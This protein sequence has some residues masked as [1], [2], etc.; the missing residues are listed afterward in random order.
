MGWLIVIVVVGFIVGFIIVIDWAQRA[1]R[2]YKGG[3]PAYDSCG[4]PTNWDTPGF[5]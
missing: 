4:V 2:R 3:P 1:R 5:D